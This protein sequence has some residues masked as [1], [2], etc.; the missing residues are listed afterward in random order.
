[1]DRATPARLYCLLAGGA[2]VIAGIAGFFYESSYDT[3]SSLRSDELL[4]V[5]AVNGWHNAFHLAVGALL[6]AAAGGAARPASLAVGAL[7]AVLA[8]FGFVATGDASL[9]FVAEDG[10]LL[11]LIPVNDPDNVLHLL[12]GMTGIVAFVTS[13]AVKPDRA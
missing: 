1:M 12:L 9:G 4:G 6:L 11:D 13:P 2:L 7:Y 5:L 10:A 8:V 3:G